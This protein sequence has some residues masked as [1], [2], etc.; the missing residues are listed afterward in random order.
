MVYKG[1]V[2]QTYFNLNPLEFTKG[3]LRRKMNLEFKRNNF[4][5]AFDN[6]LDQETSWKKW[7]GRL[8][9]G[10]SYTHLETTYGWM[11]DLNQNDLKT[12]T[13][14]LGFEKNIKDLRIKGKIDNQMN[15]DVYCQMHLGEGLSVD[16]GLGGF[17]GQ[18]LVHGFLGSPL[19]FGMR[20]QY[21]E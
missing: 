19:N 3:T 8:S 9:M 6:S 4:I 20:V 11:V 14:H 1:L 16:L 10:I 2:L 17:L 13:H 15:A 5:F 18:S 12:S 21:L 7:I